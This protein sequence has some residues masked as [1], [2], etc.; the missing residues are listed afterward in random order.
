MSRILKFL[1]SMLI[2]IIGSVDVFKLAFL[3]MVHI[4]ILSKC[5]QE[6]VSTDHFA[7]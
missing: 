6:N 2:N 5:Q 3:D 7:S 4:D 1:S